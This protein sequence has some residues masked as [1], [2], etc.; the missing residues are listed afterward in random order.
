MYTYKTCSI[1]DKRNVCARVNAH[2]HLLI[3][4]YRCSAAE[5]QMVCARVHALGNLLIHVY[6]HVHAGALRRGAILSHR[7]FSIAQA[8]PSFPNTFSST[9]IHVYIPVMHKYMPGLFF[10]ET[11]NECAHVHALMLELRYE[12]THVYA[13]APRP[14]ARL[15]HRPFNDAQANHAFP[16]TFGQTDIQVYARIASAASN[17]LHPREVSVIEVTKYLCSCADG[18]SCSLLLSPCRRC[19]QVC[20]SRENAAIAYE[21]FWMQFSVDLKRRK[22]AD[23]CTRSAGRNEFYN[24]R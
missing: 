21:R 8:K 6:S 7:P 19:V 9:Y 5:R 4:V 18:R 17:R 12:Y 11:S 13:G 20:G 1:F 2:M 24:R 16:H 23:M 22:D 14:G 3:H 10:H 15:Y